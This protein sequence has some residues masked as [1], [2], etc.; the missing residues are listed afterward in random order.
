MEAP[1]K[2]WLED[3]KNTSPNSEKSTSG[4]TSE[5]RNFIG[6]VAILLPIL[7]VLGGIVWRLPSGKGWYELIEPS[8][9]DYFDTPLRG[10]FVGLLMAISI[11]LFSYRFK[12]LDNILTNVIAILGL[13]IAFFP[14][15][16][17]EKYLTVRW[18]HLISAFSFFCIMAYI[19]LFLFTRFGE[20]PPTSKKLKR[21]KVYRVS[22]I[23]IA[24]CALAL[25]LI[26]AFIK[27]PIRTANKL[28]LF[29]EVIG[30]WFFGFAWLV[31]GQMVK[32]LWA[33][34]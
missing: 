16:F 12:I 20:D 30:L 3:L 18:I 14:I 13:C 1:K 10:V 15:T 28:I 4:F 9:S 34:T 22:G 5:L 2:S 33:D 23:V 29:P 7:V 17:G 11:F 32:E 6:V 19:C 27:E 8:I 26:F 21:N 31:K 24:I 25:L